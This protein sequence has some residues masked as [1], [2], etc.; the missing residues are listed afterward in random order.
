MDGKFKNLLL[1]IIVC[2]CIVG[3]GIIFKICHLPGANL[4]FNTGIFLE[5]IFGATIMIKMLK[6]K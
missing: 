6:N 1:I 2:T 4:I 3:I 5:I